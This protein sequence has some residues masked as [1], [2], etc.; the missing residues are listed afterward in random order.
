MTDPLTGEAITDPLAAE[1]VM[2]GETVTLTRT[3]NPT[4]Y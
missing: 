3:E 2:T 1:P 4:D